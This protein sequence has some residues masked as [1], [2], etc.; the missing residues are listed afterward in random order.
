MTTKSLAAS[1]RQPEFTGVVLLLTYSLL[2]VGGAFWLWWQRWA[3]FTGRRREPVSIIDAASAG[4]VMPV[5]WLIVG[6]IG[7]VWLA[8]WMIRRWRWGL[9]AVVPGAVLMAGLALA[10]LSAARHASQPIV[11]TVSTRLC[12]GA[13]YDPSPARARLPDCAVAEPQPGFALGTGSEPQRYRSDAAGRADG[14]P[15]GRYDARL[16]IALPPEVGQAEVARVTDGGVESFLLQPGEV[17]ADG[18]RSWFGLVEIGR[19]RAWQVVGYTS[20][21]TALPNQTITIQLQTCTETSV[22][23][24]DPSRCRPAEVT[25]PVLREVRAAG[26]TARPASIRQDGDVLQI[27]NLEAREYVFVTEQGTLTSV[28]GR[29]DFVLRRTERGVPQGENLLALNPETGQ[30]E[31][32][33]TMDAGSGSPTYVLYI[34]P[35]GPTFVMRPVEAPPIWLAEAGRD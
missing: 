18:G 20:G 29:R 24:L 13:V 28:S 31:V 15:A 26:S 35:Q 34:V 25:D 9:A 3:P 19:A 7:L 4:W 27:G 23:A 17:T 11:F 30:E 14:L 22:A 32:R 21:A 16:E 8:V 6:Q 33:L 1:R 10:G 12:A 5:V 2:S